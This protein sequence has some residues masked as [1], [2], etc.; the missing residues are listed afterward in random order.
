MVAALVGAGRTLIQV[1]T[2]VFALDI[3]QVEA[4]L[5]FAEVASKG[6]HTLSV[7]WA[8]VL[9]CDTFI[10]IYTSPP[11]LPQLQPHRRADAADL[12]L[13][14]LTAVLT[15][16]SRA[17]PGICTRSIRHD[18]VTVKAV[19]FVTS[20]GVHAAMLTG[21]R[22]QA[23]LIQILITRLSSVSW[24]TLAFVGANTLPV[25]AAVVTLSLTLSFNVFLPAIATLQ[26]PAIATYTRLVSSEDLLVV[27]IG[28]RTTRGDV[29]YEKKSTDQGG[30]LH[31]GGWE[32]PESS[33]SHGAD[34]G[35]CEFR[36]FLLRAHAL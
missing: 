15:V 12:P 17:R 23:A 5:A 21:T 18:G 27:P 2:V 13:N 26:P 25:F 4:F 32:Q 3:F 36:L 22:F 34:F 6:V 24:E 11:I 35:F 9:P 7:V 33:A 29:G 30:R 28:F 1:Y 16:S 20:I 31:V 19:A 10:N 14:L 8:E